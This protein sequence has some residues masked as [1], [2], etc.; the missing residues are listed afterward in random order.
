MCIHSNHRIRTPKIAAI[1]I[2]I[3]PI[4]VPA[5]LLSAGFNNGAELHSPGLPF[6][7]RNEI[8]GVSIQQKKRQAVE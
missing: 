4:A 8:G 5:V 1:P 3:H 2:P 7:L 6:I